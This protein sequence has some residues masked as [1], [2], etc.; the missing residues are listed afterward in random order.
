MK[1]HNIPKTVAHPMVMGVTKTILAPS[2]FRM[3][4]NVAKIPATIY[5]CPQNRDEW[6]E[7]VS[8]FWDE[9]FTFSPPKNNGASVNPI[10]QYT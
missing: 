6:L 2:I 4:F 1:I 3:I 8:Q 9:N 10:P 7:P 5:F